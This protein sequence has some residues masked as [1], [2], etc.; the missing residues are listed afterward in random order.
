MTNDEVRTLADQVLQET[1]GPFGFQRSQ[2]SSGLDHDGEPA[3]RWTG[4]DHELD[5]PY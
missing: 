5:E 4:T 2:V 1:L 3:E